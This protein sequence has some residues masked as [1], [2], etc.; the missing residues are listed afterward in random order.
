LTTYCL[1]I[2]GVAM[3]LASI[4]YVA[5]YHLK[6]YGLISTLYVAFVVPSAIA[7]PL[8][9]RLARRIGKSR[10]YRI[11]T[12]M[13]A[14]GGVAMYAA[15]SSGRNEAVFAVML[16]QGIAFAG[17]QVLPW[18]MLP[19]TILA[20]AGR[21]GHVQAGT[22]SG[23]FTAMETAMF[24]IGPGVFSLILAVS[25]FESSTFDA[26]VAQSSSALSGILLGFTLVPAALVAASL[27][28]I[29]RYERTDAAH[30]GDAPAAA[31]PTGVSP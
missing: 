2:L 11:D 21:T 20:D 26:P 15:I 10:A 1:Q 22:F 29:S 6:D 4:A 23:M 16:L 8:W 7:V 19:D 14:L 27:P 9:T 12:I 3:T 24:A 25:G 18:A 30:V 13:L 5:T 28:I 17:Q 31:S